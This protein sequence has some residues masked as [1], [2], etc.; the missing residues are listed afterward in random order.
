[1]ESEIRP[2]LT[3]FMNVMESRLKEHANREDWRAL[4][5]YY[6][7][8]CLVSNVGQIARAFQVNNADLILK[9]A[10]DAANYSMMIADLY[11]KLG[12]KKK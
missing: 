10:A 1:M 8:T 11:G 3:A 4:N 12:S 6:L 5:F 7:V 9:S 2:E